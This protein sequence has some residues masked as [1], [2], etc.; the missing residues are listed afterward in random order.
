MPTPEMIERRKTEDKSF[1]SDSRQW[2]GPS[3]AHVKTQPWVDVMSFGVLVVVESS[4]GGPPPY[5]VLLKGI[6]GK[7]TGEVEVFSTLDS[8]VERWSP[9]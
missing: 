9:D 5:Q 1:F 2:P 6:D 7:F 3:H 4:D 8:L